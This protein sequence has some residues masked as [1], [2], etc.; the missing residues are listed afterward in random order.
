M[1]EADGVTT[2]ELAKAGDPIDTL[3]LADVFAGIIKLDSHE[4]C[5]L[6][7]ALNVVASI[8]VAS[9]VPRLRIFANDPSEPDHIV[10]LVDSDPGPSRPRVRT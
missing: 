4:L 8:P 6:D 1:N 10:I 3:G 2:V 5:I 7:V 9:T